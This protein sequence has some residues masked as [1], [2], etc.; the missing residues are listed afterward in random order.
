LILPLGQQRHQE[1]TVITRQGNDFIR[2][3]IESVVFVPLLS[4]KI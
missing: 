3:T 2:E 1:L 4:G